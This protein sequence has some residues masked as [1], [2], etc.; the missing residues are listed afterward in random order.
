MAGSRL[1]CFCLGIGVGGAVGLL[2]APK[3]GDEFVDDLRGR[4]SEGRD[5]L[6]ERGG[7]LRHQAE[8]ILE[9][10]RGVVA[11]RREQLEAALQAGRR[12]YREAA[13]AELELGEGRPS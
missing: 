4:A 3:T 8:E 9:Q 13:D 1:S 7:T 6:R 11:N 10:G 12:A 5:Y 2:L